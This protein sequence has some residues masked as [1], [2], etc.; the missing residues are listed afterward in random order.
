V[1]GRIRVRAVAVALVDHDEVEEAGGEFTEELLALL[2]AGDGLI[3]AEVNLVGGIDALLVEGSVARKPGAFKVEFTLGLPTQ[4]QPPTVVPVYS[5]IRSGALTNTSPLRIGR[6]TIG[7]P[8]SVFDGSI[9]E[10]EFFS[11]AVQD[12]SP[13]YNAKCYG[14]CK[15]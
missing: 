3:E 7:V 12:F 2:R 8:G 11:R 10:V 4:N 6:V 13:I 15:Y 9:D 1:P 5:P 14:K